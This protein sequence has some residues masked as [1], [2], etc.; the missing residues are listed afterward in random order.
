MLLQIL[1]ARCFNQISYPPP[2]SEVTSRRPEKEKKD[3]K[4]EYMGV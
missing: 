1:A 2:V 4:A 3:E